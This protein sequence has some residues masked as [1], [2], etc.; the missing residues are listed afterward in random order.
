[1]SDTPLAGIGGYDSI[2]V[3]DKPTATGMGA[4]LRF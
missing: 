1:M 4:K 2:D 3:K